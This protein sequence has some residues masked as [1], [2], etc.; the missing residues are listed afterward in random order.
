MSR[1]MIMERVAAQ[2]VQHSQK[3]TWLSEE[4]NRDKGTQTYKSA[5]DGVQALGLTAKN[6]GNEKGMTAAG[7]PGAEL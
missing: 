2:V 5:K 7:P 3:M 4:E 1:Q 6:F